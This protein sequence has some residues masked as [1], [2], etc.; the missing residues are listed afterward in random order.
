MN[1]DTRSN[2][3]RMSHRGF[4]LT[5]WF[6]SNVHVTNDAVLPYKYTAPP[7]RSKHAALVPLLADN[8]WVATQKRGI[9]HDAHQKGTDINLHPKKTPTTITIENERKYSRR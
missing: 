6:D 2:D 1:G 5:A 3:T 8:D 7:Y 9:H 4:E